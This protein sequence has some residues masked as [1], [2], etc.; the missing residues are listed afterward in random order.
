[1]SSLVLYEVEFRGGQE[2]LLKKYLRHW[3][4]RQIN[5]R[6]EYSTVSWTEDIAW[7]MLHW[8]AGLR[9]LG[10]SFSTAGSQHHCW[11]TGEARAC[12][13]CSLDSYVQDRVRLFFF[14]PTPFFTLWNESYIPN[15]PDC[16]SL[17]YWKLFASG[18]KNHEAGV[19][20][21][22]FSLKETML[23]QWV[24]Y[25]RSC[26][27]PSSVAHLVKPLG[28]GNLE[29]QWGVKEQGDLWCP[30]DHQQRCLAASILTHI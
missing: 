8:I 12:V 9:A 5:P 16:P 7:F 11:R 29:R 28:S 4:Q 25:L 27:H 13:T 19:W 24:F 23:H 20:K 17:Y 26:L 18:V 30:R 15:K 6:N 2:E 21:K 3:K 1:M 22:V 10:T 14:W